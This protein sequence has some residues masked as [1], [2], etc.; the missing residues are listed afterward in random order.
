[1]QLRTT[2]DCGEL[3]FVQPDKNPCKKNGYRNDKEAT[4]KTLWLMRLA[5]SAGFFSQ[6]SAQRLQKLAYT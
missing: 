4:E 5:I 2:Y 6:K 3:E 1:M